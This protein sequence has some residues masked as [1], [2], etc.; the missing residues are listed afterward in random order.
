MKQLGRLRLGNKKKTQPVISTPTTRLTICAW[1]SKALEN[2]GC[3]ERWALQVVTIICKSH[4][5]H[6][7]QVYVCKHMYTYT[8]IQCVRQLSRLKTAFLLNTLFMGCVFKGGGYLNYLE[9][10]TVLQVIR[11]PPRS[12]FQHVRFTNRHTIQLL[13]LNYDK[14]CT[15]FVLIK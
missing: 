7:A 9:H 3:R 14:N 2:A 11:Y 8:H 5:K 10:C 15:V 6:D 12:T 1:F 4:E 13:Y